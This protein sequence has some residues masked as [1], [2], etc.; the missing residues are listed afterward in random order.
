MATPKPGQIRC[1]TCHGSTPPASFCT[2][3]GQPIP[4]SVLARPRG[5]DRD[6]LQERLRRR[7]PEGPYRRGALA[8]E[9]GAAAAGAFAQPFEPEP[10]DELAS[11][12]PPEVAEAEPRV[13]NLDPG[14]EAPVVEPPVDPIPSR[15]PRNAPK[16]PEAAPYRSEPLI[17]VQPPVRSDEPSPPAAA[18]PAVAAQPEEEYFEGYDYTYD[19]AQS[20]DSDDGPASGASPL[21][22]A[23]IIGL[24][25]VALFGGVL[26]SGILGRVP[27]VG[28]AS[29]TPTPTASVSQPVTPKP[30]IEAS[31]VPSGSAVAS[32]GPPGT[33]ADG[34]TASVQPCASSQMTRSG[35]VESGATLSG[36]TVWVWAGFTNGTG[37][38]VVGVTLVNKAGTALQDTS[39][40]L[41]KINC[42]QVCN[43]YLKFS[44]SGLAPG[45]YS[46]RV[47]RNGAPAAE[48]P[49][50][51]S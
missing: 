49:F 27:G 23:G 44:F 19:D 43:G 25:L 45:S 2:Q 9:G 4:A 39:L 37:N 18:H 7:P 6:E 42:G 16:L 30:T 47:N 12:V 32:G 10:A 46:L 22:I 35:C 38:D 36:G 1:P 21:L 13:D 51:V 48:A 14:S 40:E 17:A 3:C 29:L 50:T 5:M 26:L 20:Y 24:G 31:P 8:V 41:S 33:F 11:R 28:Q 34:F 15:W